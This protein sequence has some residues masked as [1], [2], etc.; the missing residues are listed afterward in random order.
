MPDEGQLIVANVSLSTVFAK[1]APILQAETVKAQRLPV[2][3]ALC[4]P[5]FLRRIAGCGTCQWEK[6]KKRLHLT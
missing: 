5:L 1:I 6:S 4:K 2:L 3:A